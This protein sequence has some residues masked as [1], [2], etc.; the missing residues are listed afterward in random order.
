MPSKTDLTQGSITGTLLRFTIPMIIG[1]LLQQCYNIADTLIVGQCLGSNAL[2]AV[3]SAYTLMVFLISILLGLSM[4]SSTIF[5]LQYGARQTDALHRSI[6]MSA[7]L[8]GTVTLVMNIT[9]FIG[10]HPILGLLQ[11][12][13]NI[14]SM[15]YDYLWIIFWGIGPTFIYNFYAALLR[16]IGDSVTPLCFLAVSV[17]L[18]IGLDLFFILQLDWGIKGAA[19]ATITSQG[20]A[21]LGIMGY[22]YMKYP[23]LR[24]RRTD[25]HFDRYCLKEI[26]SFSALTCVQQSVMNL[27]ILMVQGLVNSFGTIVM[28]AFAA[29]IKIDSFAYMPVQ[30]FGNAFSTFIAQNF[31]ARK[32]ERIRK[33]IRRAL[34]ITVLFSMIVSALVFLFARPLMLI[35]I[36]PHETE[37][38]NIGIN[39]LHIEGTFYCGIG[40]LFLLYGY[41]RAICMPKMSVLLTVIS[42]GS[43]VVLSYW[44]AGIPSVG[45]TG[46]WWSIP[47][48]WFIADLIGLGYYKY[49]QKRMAND[50]KYMFCQ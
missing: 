24:L 5:S 23:E 30:E 13:S 20:V 32:E 18:N 27:G 16:A 25:L 36:H 40:I 14:Y 29:A 31:G 19:A 34:V 43:R 48:G 28:A 17:G 9:V 7:L 3:G 39:Y 46:I 2:A 33:G 12:P 15:M 11:I 45:I 26:T 47:I 8:T 4:G 41:Y 6:Y 50:S 35:F 22:T 37:I 21:A 44:L 42:L 1:S 49:R 10:I 38:L